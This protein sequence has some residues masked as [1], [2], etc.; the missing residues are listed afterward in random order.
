MLRVTLLLFAGSLGAAAQSAAETASIGSATQDAV[1]RT[2]PDPAWLAE[3]HRLAASRETPKPSGF[4]KASLV[5]LVAGSTADIHSSLGRRELNPLLAGSTGRFSARGIAIKSAITGGAIATQWLL[6][7]KHPEVSN[8]A[9]IANFGMA[10]VF[11]HTASR[12]YG[13]RAPVLGQ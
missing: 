8:Y 13:N 1:F 7:R 10:G 12:N 9:A 3:Q 6:V 2:S 11:A 5:A 4:W